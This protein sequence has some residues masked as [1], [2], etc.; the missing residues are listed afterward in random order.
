MRQ[1]AVIAVAVIVIAIGGVA[2]LLGVTGSDDAPATGAVLTWDEPPLVFIPPELPDDR[3][4]YG[5]VRNTSLEGLQ[6]G[7]KDFEVRDANGTKLDASV[8]FLGSYAHGLYGA[9]QKPH[10]LPSEELS[11]LGLHVGLKSGQTSPLT[12]SYRLT[13]ESKLPATLYYRGNPALDLPDPPSAPDAPDA[14]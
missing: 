10:P 5:T 14:G 3:V 2:I 11:R 6:A 9:F 13:A 4:A 12:V 7:T 8:Q 1:R